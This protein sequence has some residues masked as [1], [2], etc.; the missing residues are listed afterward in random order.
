M[1][2]DVSNYR[3]SRWHGL[4]C[5]VAL[6]ALVGGPGIAGV[7]ETL[8]GLPGTGGGGDE[9]QRPDL[10]SSFFVEGT[11]EEVTRVVASMRG[12]EDDELVEVSPGIVRRIFH[13]NYELTLDEYFLDTTNVKMGILASSVAGVTKYVITSN[14]ART[15]LFSVPEGGTI[16]LPFARV[17]ASGMLDEPAVLSTF[18]LAHP[19]SDFAMRR[20][21][22][23]VHVVIQH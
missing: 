21:G 22:G 14:E 12:A 23:F 16:D 5:A 18:S 10:R 4:V 2:M 8:G 6:V 13:G 17:K 11:F 7:D 15:P 3:P 9:L 19:R 20:A 1:N